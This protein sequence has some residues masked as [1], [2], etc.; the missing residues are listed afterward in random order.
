MDEITPTIPDVPGIDIGAYKATLIERF[1]N[2]AIRDQVQRLAE[3]GAKKIRNFVVPPLRDHL[4]GGGSIHSIAFALAA[5][6]RYL[7][8]VDEQGKPIDSVDPLRAVLMERAAL[9]PHDPTQLL[10]VAHV[11]GEQEAADNRIAS[12]VKDCLDA[13]D[14]L[15]MRQACTWS[16]AGA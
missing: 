14:R 10:A 8:G 15:G 11:F 7:R 6:F 3:D 1:G 12:A 9:H 4:A 5:W 13:I 2:A 16:V